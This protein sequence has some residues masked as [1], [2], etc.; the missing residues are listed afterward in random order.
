MEKEPMTNYGGREAGRIDWVDSLFTYGMVLVVLGHVILTD[1]DSSTYLS[2][3]IYGFHMPLF[4][5]LAGVLFKNDTSIG[6]FALKKARRLLVPLVV[7]TCIAYIPK[8]YLSDFAFHTVSQDNNVVVSLLRAIVC[9]DDNPISLMWFLNALFVVYL[10]GAVLAKLI[11]D[12]TS[13]WGLAFLI[14]A[15]GMTYLPYTQISFFGIS[16]ALYYFP[17]FCLGIVS[18]KIIARLDSQHLL[19]PHRL[20]LLF[21]ILNA[22]YCALICLPVNN[23]LISI[24]G[25]FAAFALMKF[26]SVNKIRFM[27]SLRKYTYT[28]YLLQ[29]FPMVAVRIILFQIL[30]WDRWLCYPIMFLAGLYIPVLIGKLAL[31][32]IPKKAPGKYALISIG[33]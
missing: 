19:P 27:P 21:V 26:L 33:L 9:P 4:F 24:T 32:Y 1:T 28:I 16:L 8:Y 7:L 3:W 10:I 31:R 22:L 14:G 2:H 11:K 20:L 17:Y 25:I 29:W 30:G 18:K 23:Y 13:L 6:K 5:W 15:L 12:K